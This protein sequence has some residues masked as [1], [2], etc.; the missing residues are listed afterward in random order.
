M[1]DLFLIVQPEQRLDRDPLG[2]L[3]HF[4]VQLDLGE[5]P[6]AFQQQPCE[7]HHVVMILPDLPCMEGWL[8]QMTMQFVM[9]PVHIQQIREEEAS[10]CG[11]FRPLQDLPFP[12]LEESG[13]RKQLE[14]ERMPKGKD[15]GGIALS[16]R[17]DI[18][19]GV[20]QPARVGTRV[21]EQ[22]E[23][24]RPAAKKRQGGWAGKSS[25]WNGTC[26]HKNISMLFS[27]FVREGKK[28]KPEQSGRSLSLF[29]FK[30]QECREDAVRSLSVLFASSQT[31]SPDPI[32]DR[33]AERGLPGRTGSRAHQPE[34]LRA[35]TTLLS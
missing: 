25:L 22:F 14:V 31:A 1:V 17:D 26:Y 30:K 9:L 10:Q 18:S 34:P 2:E 19:V 21:A 11:V 4:S 15:V 6:P 16:H 27:C 32:R 35:D 5:R 8:H 7:R 23:Q 20:V 3:L 29:L 24:I 33:R 28:P 13:L 12:H